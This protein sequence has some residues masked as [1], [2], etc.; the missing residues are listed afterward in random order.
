M[1]ISEKYVDYAD[2]VRSKLKKSGIRVTFDDRDDKIGYKIRQAQMEKVPYMLVIG[3]KEEEEKVVSV[4]LR[5]GGDAG[6]LS[7]AELIKDL[8]EKIDTREL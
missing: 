3:A 2:S 6:Q 1:S 7:L 5:D 4:R 8:K